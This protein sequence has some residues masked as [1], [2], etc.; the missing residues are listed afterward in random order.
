VKVLDFGLAKELRLRHAL[1]TAVID[2]DPAATQVAEFETNPGYTLGTI[3]Y[4]SPEQARGE[5]VD[6]RSDI[7]SLGIVLYEMA[8]GREP[9]QGTTSAVVFDAI[10]NRTPEAPIRLNA[11]IPPKLNDI[12]ERCLE[13]D[14]LLRYQTAADLAADL[15]RVRRTLSAPSAAIGRPA[16][17]RKWPIY[18]FTGV[19]VFLIAAAALYFG[20]RQTRT[21]IGPPELTRMTSNPVEIPITSAVVSPSGRYLA[22]ADQ[23]GVH[24]KNLETKYVLPFAKKFGLTDAR[25][26]C[27]P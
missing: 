2:V 5:A 6:A 19:G 23:Q 8:T 7:F 1:S 13:K 24:V 3:A 10:L 17:R 21:A 9:F 18:G 14:K 25:H 27:V 11:D 15:Q 16:A 4:M 26:L 12:I 22:Y 20:S